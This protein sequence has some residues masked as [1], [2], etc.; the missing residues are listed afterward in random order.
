MRIVLLVLALL[1]GTVAVVEGA[2]PCDV[3]AAPDCYVVL[4]PGPTRDVLDIV[5]VPDEDVSTSDGQLVLTT[6]VVDRSLDLS[7]L[8]RT[9]SDPTADRAER[10]EYF[11]TDVDPETTRQAFRALMQESETTAAVAALTELG[12]DLPPDGARIEAVV[13][14]GPSSGVLAVGDVVV[15]VDGA[16]VTTS[17]E[18]ADAVGARAPGEQV[19]VDVRGAESTGGESTGGASTGGA[20]TGE[21]TSGPAG[22]G[23]TGVTQRT[24]TLGTNP[25]DVQRGFAGLFVSTSIDIPVELDFDVDDIGGPSA[26]LMFALAIVDLLSDE[27]LT[28]GEVVAGTGEIAIDGSVGAIGGIRQKLAGAVQRPDDG[29]GAPASVFLLPRDNVTEARTAV[30]GEDLLL[31]PVDTLGDAVDA[32]RALA[33]GDAPLDSFVLPADG[34]GEPAR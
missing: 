9:R 27:D 23:T 2:L 8:L 25:E 5:E 28:S 12:Y 14:D 11:P 19:T 26:G 20:S 7:E 13:D 1:A 17:E 34:L 24:I 6:V 3:V 10:A 32:L 31:V 21:G 30:P 16:A 4:R 15:A 33:A 29:G 22:S 18:F